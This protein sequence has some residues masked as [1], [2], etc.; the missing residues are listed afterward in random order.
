MA[1]DVILYYSVPAC[2]AA[3]VFFLAQFARRWHESE[4]DRLRAWL[5][6]AAVA[7]PAVALSCFLPAR[8]GYDNNHDFLCLGRS[9]FSDPPRLLLN[10]KELSPLFTDGLSDILSGNS[11]SA[12]LWKNRLLPVLSIFV[13]FTGLRR[14]RAGITVSAVS[15][16]LLFLNF[17]SPLNASSFSTTSANVFIWLV[18]LLA[19]IDA[20]ASPVPGPAALAWIISSMVIVISSRF[21]FLPVNLLAFAALAALM[22]AKERENFFKPANLALMACGIYLIGL[23][24][25]HELGSDPGR[26]LGMPLNPLKHFIYQLGARNLAVI[27]GAAPPYPG[28]QDTGAPSAASLSA[29]FSYLFILSAFTGIAAGLRTGAWKNKRTTAALIVLTAW[30]VYFSVIFVPL[31]F[32]PLHFIR[33]Q[34]YFFV[35]F[36]FLSALALAGLESAA[37]RKERFKRAFYPLCWAAAGTYAALNAAAALGLNGELRTNDRE[38]AFL[39]EAQRAWPAGCRVL[40]SQPD[41]L[42]TRRPL[43]EKYFPAVSA[44]PAGREKCLMAYVSPEPRIF[45]GRKAPYPD[46]APS[47]AWRSIT[48][49]HAFYTA[50]SGSGEETTEPVPLTV[51]FFRLESGS[52]RTSRGVQPGGTPA[53]K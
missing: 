24:A 1:L 26:Q 29:V 14:L 4:P 52:G 37:L 12:I 25:V 44:P 46:L 3:V 31:D 34:L 15:A 50:F 22:P 9:F 43:L 27:A 47:A 36:A 35:P 48:F 2:W 42:D 19:L 39:M 13:F 28:P 21:E 20:Y 41:R 8:G 11:L 33:H 45:T 6:L 51:G 16:A 18:S 10:F 53:E 5:A 30:I 40:L 17:L 32:Y 7:V 38:L 49:N 23:W